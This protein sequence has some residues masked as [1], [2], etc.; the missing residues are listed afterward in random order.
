MIESPSSLFDD[1]L[2]GEDGRRCA[3][4][5]AGRRRCR[6]PRRRGNSCSSLRESNRM[7]H[8]MSSFL[9]PPIPPWHLN[10][11]L[12]SLA[13]TGS[14]KI[15]YPLVPTCE[16]GSKRIS[17]SAL[18]EFVLFYSQKLAGKSF[19]DLAYLFL[20]A[21]TRSANIYFGLSKW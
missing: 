5:R 16:P 3:W 4:R 9:N 17:L 11:K 12:N 20:W 10:G 18:T 1:W 8:K 13:R 6:R 2:R 15:F 7:E 19:H 14:S 21:P